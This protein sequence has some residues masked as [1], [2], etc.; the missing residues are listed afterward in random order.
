[1]QQRSGGGG[2]RCIGSG[3]ACIY[4]S[5]SGL[6]HA[7][8]RPLAFTHCGAT[9]GVCQ[10][11]ASQ[12]T[13]LNRVNAN[14]TQL[15]LLQDRLCQHTGHLCVLLCEISCYVLASAVLLLL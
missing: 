3:R 8:S 10:Y 13:K 12:A 11:H 5:I 14:N 15:Q 7:A 4:S 1:M 9:S 2:A 6:R